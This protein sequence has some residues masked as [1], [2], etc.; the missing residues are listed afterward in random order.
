LRK[1]GLELWIGLKYLGIGLKF[2]KEKEKPK[3][4]R[5]FEFLYL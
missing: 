4:D 3:H 2:I 5:S 1:E